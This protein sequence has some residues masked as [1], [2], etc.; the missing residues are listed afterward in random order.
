[1]VNS[2]S[3]KTR[4]LGTLPRRERLRIVAAGTDHENHEN[5]PIHTFAFPGGT[6]QPR[7]HFP[8]YAKVNGACSYSRPPV[9]F[10]EVI[11]ASGTASLP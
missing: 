8:S 7:Y 3:C 5:G 10:Q 9:A 11:T 4:F 6:F 2:V 1:M